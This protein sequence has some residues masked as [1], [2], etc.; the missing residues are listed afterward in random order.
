MTFCNQVCTLPKKGKIKKVLD[1]LEYIL[2]GFE[3]PKS[4]VSSLIEFNKMLQQTEVLQIVKSRG[5][6]DKVLAEVTA[7]DHL[8]CCNLLIMFC[9]VDKV[10]LDSKLICIKECVEGIDWEFKAANKSQQ[11]SEKEVIDLLR[12]NGIGNLKH[13]VVKIVFDLVNQSRPVYSCV[14]NNLFH[15]HFD[16]KVDGME[17][18][19]VN[20]VGVDL[21]I[22]YLEKS[23]G[24]LEYVTFCGGNHDLVGVSL[25]QDLFEH[26]KQ[27][28]AASLRVLL[29]I[30]K[31]EYS[32]TY[33]GSLDLIKTYVLQEEN[34]AAYLA[35]GVLINIIESTS[36]ETAGLL[37]FTKITN[38]S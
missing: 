21:D 17:E 35:I 8:I 27:Q 16:H 2:Q 14:V 24:I 20:I 9:M 36:L 38:H 6:F 22:T 19:I 7:K 33:L 32:S 34:D 29:N 13:L 4:T 37:F 26:C 1:T 12:Q 28:P 30:Y 18:W 23:L 10:Y 5:F 15:V 31:K 3:T 11:R 25:V